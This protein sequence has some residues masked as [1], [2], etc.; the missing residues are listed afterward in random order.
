MRV[1]FVYTMTIICDKCL[2]IVSHVRSRAGIWA[3]CWIAFSLSAHCLS[4]HSEPCLGSVFFITFRGHDIFNVPSSIRKWRSFTICVQGSPI[5]F[6]A[7]NKSLC[8]PD[9]GLVLADMAGNID[10]YDSGPNQMSKRKTLRRHSL[11]E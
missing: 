7:K 9:E 3:L 6:L 4:S 10:R 2:G 1:D 5:F 8:K 11:S